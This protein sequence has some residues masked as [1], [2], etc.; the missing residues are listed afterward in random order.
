MANWLYLV[1][2]SFFNYCPIVKMQIL[3]PFRHILL[4]ILCVQIIASCQMYRDPKDKAADLMLYNAYV[5]PVQAPSIENGAVVIRDGKI[6][7]S[8]TTQE[9]EEIWGRH[10]EKKLDCKGSFLMPGF[11]EGHGHFS[12]LGYNL[13]QLDLLE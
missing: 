3:T 6:L 11:I 12:G 10:V 2:C 13:I 9:M 4:V 5:Y 8:G 7:Q 1:A